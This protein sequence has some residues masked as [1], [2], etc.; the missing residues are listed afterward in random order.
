MGWSDERGNAMVAY[1]LETDVV[2][3]LGWGWNQKGHGWVDDRKSTRSRVSFSHQP[4]LNLVEIYL[5]YHVL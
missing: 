2:E 3:G 4:I 5:C 1:K